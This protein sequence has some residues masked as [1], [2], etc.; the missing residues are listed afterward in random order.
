M[1]IVFNGRFGKNEIFKTFFAYLVTLL[2]LPKHNFS[3]LCIL[4]ELFFNCRELGQIINLI[5][6]LILSMSLFLLLLLWASTG[7]VRIFEEMSP[8][9]EAE[10]KSMIVNL[11]FSIRI[12]SGE[13]SLTCT[14]SLLIVLK[15]LFKDFCIL[16]IKLR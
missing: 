8:T 5:R 9:K 12:F 13:M 10:P 7:K 4:Y 2:F 16:Y 3:A 14:P 1:F 6:L 15:I 11:S